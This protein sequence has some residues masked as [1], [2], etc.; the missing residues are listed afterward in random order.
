[1]LGFKTEDQVLPEKKRHQRDGRD[2]QTQARERGTKGEI[3]ARLEP[4]CLCCAQRGKPLRH[5]NDKSYRHTDERFGQRRSFD[6]MFHRDGKHLGQKHDRQERDGKT[7][8]GDQE[9]PAR[10]GTMK[11][12]GIGRVL[13]VVAM[14]HR[15]GAQ[16]RVIGCE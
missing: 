12:P 14:T 11:H 16:D 2:C 9:V 4:A 6:R 10:D 7:R 8:Q 13:K 15:L 5:K 1:M 3:D